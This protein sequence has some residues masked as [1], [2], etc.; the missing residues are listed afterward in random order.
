VRYEQDAARL[1]IAPSEI[2]S[3]LDEALRDAVVAAVRGAGFRRVVL[4]LAG[5]RSGSLNDD[6]PR[7]SRPA[8]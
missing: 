7:A 4:D 3:C 1:E 5:F 8:G 6:L 2:A